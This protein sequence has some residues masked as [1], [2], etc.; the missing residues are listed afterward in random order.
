MSL[1]HLNEPSILHVLELR[2]LRD[3]I[4]TY[5]GRI[6]LSINPF[7]D[8]PLYTLEVLEQ[9]VAAGAAQP[10]VV[11]AYDALPPHVFAMADWAYQRM[12]QGR[13]AQGSGRSDGGCDLVGRLTCGCA[14]WRL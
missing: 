7:R 11:E 13:L 1:V 2:F 10:G 9:Y 14:V 5:S 6:L 8:L 12:V 3:R 4:Y